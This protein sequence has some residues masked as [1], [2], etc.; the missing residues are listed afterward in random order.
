MTKVRVLCTLVLAG[1]LA[2]CSSSSP[3]D[4]VDA[5]VDAGPP[6]WKPVVSGLSGTLLSIWGTSSKDIWAVGGPL[7][8][9]GAPTVLRFDG[10]AWTAQTLGGDETFWWVHGT[11]ASDVWLVGE[12]G[13]IVHWDGTRFEERPSGTT[14]TLFGVWAAAPN[15]AWAVGGTPDAPASPNDVVLH[16]DGATWKPETLPQT[17]KSA[18]FKVWGANANDLWIVGENAIMWHR[19][20]GTWKREA[21]GVAKGRLTTIHGCSPTEIVAVGGR[22][23][24]EY[25]GNTWKR[26][27]L[28]LVNDVNGV[29][30]ANGKTDHGRF[31]IV[32]GGS[33]KL[34][35]VGAEWVD[36]FGSEPF[37]DL[38]GAWA[39]ENGDFWGAGGSFNASPRPGASRNGVVARYGVGV[40]PNTVR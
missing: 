7:G 2:G 18:L 28:P 31:V 40:V 10:A 33:L 13:R 9:G 35:R 15:D 19:K 37:Q 22:D 26:S 20:D 6:E 5:G 38:H 4:P 1:L 24:L 27:A 17:N 32:G 3:P 8:N 12:R 39:D 21:E 23:L 30:C 34:R 25:D 14:A 36:D 16:W 29:A 11:S